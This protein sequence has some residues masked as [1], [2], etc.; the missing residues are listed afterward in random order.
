MAKK[1][2][3]GRER[4]R[5]ARM[6]SAA[7]KRPV[8]KATPPPEADVRS[9]AEKPEEPLRT[10]SAEP[11]SITAESSSPKEA[12][13]KTEKPSVNES[14]IE[15]K[16]V[17]E[18]QNEI[19]E[20]KKFAPKTFSVIQKEGATSATPEETPV[21]SEI[22]SSSMAEQTSNQG[23]GHGSDEHGRDASQLVENV[24]KKP[25]RYS[26]LAALGLVLV[27]FLSQNYGP[28]H[29]HGNAEAS[30]VEEGKPEVVNDEAMPVMEESATEAEEA[31]SPAEDNSAPAEETGTSDETTSSVS[32]GEVVE[33]ASTMLQKPFWGLATA[34]VDTES[35][36]QNR[37]K[38]LKAK[39]FQSSYLYIPDYI[40]QGLKLY[41]VFIGPFSTEEA[42]R[43]AQKNYDQS[44]AYIFSIK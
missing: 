41:R 34:A 32:T 27:V 16:P 30:K 42:A 37:A 44:D 15:K 6:K 3:S 28:S 36:A 18:S 24:S 23:H 1:P 26:L 4:D 29:D 35:D 5:L 2:L 38:R 40:P 12:P 10:E 25:L 9:K 7:P 11:K 20:E 19:I 14:V 17:V 21:K 43:S 13:I 33:T 31:E 8:R 22:K 39:G